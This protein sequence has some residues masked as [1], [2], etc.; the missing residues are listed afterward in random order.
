M[1]PLARQLSALTPLAK[2]G[3]SRWIGREAAVVVAIPAVGPGWARLGREQW[4][5][6][7]GLGFSAGAIPVGS[8]VLVTSVSGTH[9]IV[10]PLASGPVEF[11]QLYQPTSGLRPDQGAS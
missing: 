10:L 1:R 5:A 2:I 9:L 4:R 6:E 7:S 11:T 3:S 8:T